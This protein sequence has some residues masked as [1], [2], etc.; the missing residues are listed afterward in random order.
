MFQER[1]G[2][3]Y[4]ELQAAEALLDRIA[5]QVWDAA[6]CAQELDLQTR[7]SIRASVA[8]VTEAAAQVVDTNISRL[9]HPTCGFDSGMNCRGSALP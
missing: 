1:F 3:A 9:P 5:G 2:H 7:A 8:K 4:M 6:A